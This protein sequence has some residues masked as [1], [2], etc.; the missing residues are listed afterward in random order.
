MEKEELK[1]V[2][3]M[4]SD[5]TMKPEDAV[6]LIEAMQGQS[7]VEAET[8]ASTAK[9]EANWV[10]IRVTNIA[11]GKT[12]VNMRIPLWLVRGALKLGG[13]GLNFVFFD[14]DKK[15]KGDLTE[16]LNEMVSLGEIGTLLD[17]TDEE[18]GEHVEIVLE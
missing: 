6:R 3:N 2:L 12:K 15:M 7:P 8:K 4:V 13:K 11:T 9:G 16:K 18:E 17:V 10:K 14:S 5:G 1:K